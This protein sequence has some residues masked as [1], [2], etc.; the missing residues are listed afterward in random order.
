MYLVL[1]QTTVVLQLI[2]YLYMFVALPLIVRRESEKPGFYRSRWVPV[3]AAVTG[4]CMTLLGVGLAFVP[5]AGVADV[6]WFELKL[7]LGT[8]GFLVPA[9][10]VYL[11][12][13][14]RVR[15]GPMVPE[16]VR[17]SPE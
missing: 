17:F 13:S 3:T 11:R 10:L 1:L 16:A 5:T 6:V 8:V 9:V 7:L 2:P 15:T 4:F 14:R 12:T